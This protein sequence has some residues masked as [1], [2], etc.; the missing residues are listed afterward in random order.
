MDN[1]GS[2]KTVGIREAIKAAEPQLRFLL[3]LSLLE[4][5]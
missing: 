4:L 3:P 2:H 1:L 5:R